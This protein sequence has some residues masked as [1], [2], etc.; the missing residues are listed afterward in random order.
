LLS[1]IQKKLIL[2]SDEYNIFRRSYKLKEEK[3][4]YFVSIKK[5]SFFGFEYWKKLSPNFENKTN[6]YDCLIEVSLNDYLKK[7]KKT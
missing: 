5:N 2:H 3:N 4:N 6:A 7:K 1:D